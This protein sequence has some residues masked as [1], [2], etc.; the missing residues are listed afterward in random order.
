[1]GDAKLQADGKADQVEGR[2]QNAVG[3]LPS[4][5]LPAVGLGDV[6]AGT[7]APLR[8]A[9]RSGSKTILQAAHRLRLLRSLLKRY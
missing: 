8:L 1:M 6:A 9:S 5:H 3:G 4:G 7:A 2:V